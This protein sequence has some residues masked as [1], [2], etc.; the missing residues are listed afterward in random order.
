M[1]NQDDQL[2]LLEGQ[3]RPKQL[4]PDGFYKGRPRP[5]YSSPEILLMAAN[6]LMPQVMQ[7]GKFSDDEAPEI[8]EQVVKALKS[9][10]DGY[11]RAKYLEDRFSWDS[12][13]ELVEIMESDDIYGA[14]RNAIKAWIRDNAITPAFEIG[15]QV[16]VRADRRQSEMLI[17]KIRSLTEDGMYCV[18][19]PALGHVESGLGTH[20]LLF[21]WEDVEAWN[22]EVS[23]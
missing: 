20:G 15:K 14:T 9:D 17:G 13:S 11:H 4:I 7:W 21:P 10:T 12:D 19:V 22:A 2:V 16:S 8:A 1:E 23:P 18:M 6:G 5:N 3:T